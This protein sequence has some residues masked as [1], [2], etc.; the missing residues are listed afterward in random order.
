LRLVRSG[1]EDFAITRDEADDNG[2][3]EAHLRAPLGGTIGPGPQFEAF[4]AGSSYVPRKV[5]A[6]GAMLTG[7]RSQSLRRRLPQEPG[8]VPLQFVS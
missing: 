8:P 1:H 2:P 4:R 3:D 7:T 5:P 6:S